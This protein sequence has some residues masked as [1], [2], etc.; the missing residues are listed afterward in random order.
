MLRWLR[1]LLEV[2]PEWFVGRWPLNHARGVA[3]PQPP[4]SGFLVTGQKDEQ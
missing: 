3:V 4:A 2:D 1:E